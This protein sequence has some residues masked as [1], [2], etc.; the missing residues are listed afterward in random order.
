MGNVKPESLRRVENALWRALMNTA[1]GADQ[2]NQLN[3]F[4]QGTSNVRNIDDISALEWF[5][6]STPDFHHCRVAILGCTM[7]RN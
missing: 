5:V 1:L 6:K 4:I 2:S 3:E 7:L